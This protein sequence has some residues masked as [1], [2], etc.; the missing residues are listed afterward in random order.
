MM[1]LMQWIV[2]LEEGE[3][4]VGWAPAWADSLPALGRLPRGARRRGAPLVSRWLP[5]P[6]VVGALEVEA[7]ERGQERELLARPAP[8][9]TS[10]V[11]H[12]GIAL[13]GDARE[14]VV[15]PRADDLR[16]AG[17]FSELVRVMADLSEAAG[18]PVVGVTPAL[19]RRGVALRLGALGSLTVQQ[20]GDAVL[21][22]RVA[23]EVGLQARGLQLTDADLLIDGA[24][25]PVDGRLAQVLARMV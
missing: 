24:R 9:A 2:P 6:L 5:C 16:F 3:L 14:P 4:A 10:M 20:L 22:L 18:V 11:L 19:E 25:V 23:V 7:A 21:L 1:E 17:L 12:L 8:R 15:A 13:D